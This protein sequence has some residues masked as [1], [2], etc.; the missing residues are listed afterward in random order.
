MLLPVQAVLDY[1][2]AEHRQALLQRLEHPAAHPAQRKNSEVL[3]SGATRPGANVR[4]IS[5][6][7]RG[8]GQHSHTAQSDLF[9]T[10]GR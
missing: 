4:T 6:A 7:L 9:V 2:I 5:A 10:I 8:R 3:H 1:E